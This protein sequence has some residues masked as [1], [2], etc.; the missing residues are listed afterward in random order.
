MTAVIITLLVMWVVAEIISPPYLTPE[1]K[2][3]LKR[4]DP[5]DTWP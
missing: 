2:E 3:E 4:R 5:Q 1:Q